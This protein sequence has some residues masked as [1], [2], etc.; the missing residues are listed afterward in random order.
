MKVY[1]QLAGALQDQSVRTIFGLMGD[2]NMYFLAAFQDDGGRFV[3]VVHEASSV[4][5]ADTYSRM[6]GTLGVA[7]MTHG[8]GFTNAITSLV[9]ATRTRSKVLVIC[10]DPP[11]EPTHMQRL[12][13]EAVTSALGVGHERIYRPATLV[14]DLNR[15]VQ[16]VWAESRPVVLNVPLPVF[17]EDA[18]DQ[19]PAL[20]PLLAPPGEPSRAQLDSALGLLA[21][22]RRPLIVAG[23]GALH[24]DAR[25]SLIDLAEVLGAP[26]ATTA[27]AK[28]LFRGHP[29]D[30]G[31]VGSMSHSVASAAITD[32]DCII[33]FGASLNRYTTMGGELVQ[34][35]RIVHVDAD[36]RQIGAYVP[37]DE[38]IVGDANRVAVSI[39]NALK[40]AGFDAS[41][42]WRERIERELS[43]RSADDGFRQAMADGVVDIRSAMIELDRILPSRRVVVSDV[44]RFVVGSWPYV[45]VEAGGDFTAMTGFGSIGLGLAG[46]IGAA[47]AREGELTVALVGDGGFMM[48]AAEFST[49]VR[50]RLRLLVV[51]LNDGAYGAE[52]HKLKARNLD[53]AYSLN[54]WPNFVDMATS[55]G[56]RGATVRSMDDLTE[57][58]P[59]LADLDGPYL[60][61]VR[62][63]PELNLAY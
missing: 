34:G 22:A 18:V 36:P 20:A 38:G 54:H 50:E 61:D 44:G 1:S 43:G 14:R 25:S 21:S 53:A 40:D 5:M 11:P 56:A 32:A 48:H 49:A 47:V 4:A 27:M 10:G 8:P 52:H 19:P 28:D 9:D 7:T 33:A 29:A 16:R 35:A 26:L 24:A 59:E 55:M 58:E 6:T 62:I 15:A 3:P 60:L 42:S 2:A 57:L 41:R 46:S 39:V 17:L 31:I 12:D 45:S 23:R 51:V 63:D 13:L 30:L 37:V